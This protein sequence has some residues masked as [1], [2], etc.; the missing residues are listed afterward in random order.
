MSA[1]RN[2]EGAARPDGPSAPSPQQEDR[3]N[4]LFHG[5]APAVGVGAARLLTRRLVRLEAQVESL[6]RISALLE[7]RAR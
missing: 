3:A 7:E 6:D 1:P 4:A 2:G 5:L